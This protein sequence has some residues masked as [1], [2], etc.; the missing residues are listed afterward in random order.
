M[1][2]HGAASFEVD[3]VDHDLGTPTH[4]LVLATATGF[5]DSYQGAIEAAPVMA[6]VYGGTTDPNVR[7]DMVFY[8]TPKGG[9]VFSVGAIGFCS[10][11]SYNH[12][13]NHVSAIL[14]NVVRHFSDPAPL[15]R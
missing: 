3:R 10:A 11:L 15:P 5:S 12:Y 2:R 7:A 14:E 13:D 8:E 9:A 6:P 1:C 4:A